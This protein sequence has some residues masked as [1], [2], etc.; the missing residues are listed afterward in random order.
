MNQSDHSCERYFMKMALSSSPYTQSDNMR[1]FR[2]LKADM[3]LIQYEKADLE[4]KLLQLTSQHQKQSSQF[5]KMEQELKIEKEKNRKL[6]QSFNEYRMRS[7]DER[8]GLVTCLRQYALTKHLNSSQ[9][10][11][12]ELESFTNKISTLEVSFVM[13]FR[14]HSWSLSLLIVV[15]IF[16]HFLKL[17]IPLCSEVTEFA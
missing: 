2:E 1:T 13:F 4:Q 3:V 9:Y 16:N 10:K 5:V 6:E 14:V 15:V 8:D 12:F 7:E 17:H 11:E